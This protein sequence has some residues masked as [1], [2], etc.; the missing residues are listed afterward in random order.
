MLTYSAFSEKTSEI[1]LA[2]PLI[3]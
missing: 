2:R 3:L 1:C